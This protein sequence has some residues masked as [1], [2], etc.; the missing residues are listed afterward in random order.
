MSARETEAYYRRQNVRQRRQ[1]IAIPLT[2]RPLFEDVDSYPF[3]VEEDLGAVTCHREN[4]QGTLTILINGAGTGP[5]QQ[6]PARGSL[7]NI[8][9]GMVLQLRATGAVRHDIVRFYGPQGN[10]IGWTKIGLT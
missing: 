7:G 6:K 2:H 10:E 9:A 1:R 8:T 3:R 4:T 5:I